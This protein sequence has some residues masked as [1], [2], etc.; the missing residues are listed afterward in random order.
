MASAAREL[1][2]GREQ[3]WA[4]LAEP[5]HLSDWWPGVVGVEPDRRGFATGARW[6][7][8]RHGPR[9]PLRLPQG[10]WLGRARTETL[11]ITELAAPRLWRFELIGAAAAG[12]VPTRLLTAIELASGS[13]GRTAVELSVASGA[14][15]GSRDR[16]TARAALDRLYA[17]VQ[18]A[19]SI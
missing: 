17:L 5:Y 9:G 12:R 3:L 8:V 10:S 2:A 19:G 6:R 13:P 4:F 1:L 11:V 7:V 18:T 14:L 16:L 15:A